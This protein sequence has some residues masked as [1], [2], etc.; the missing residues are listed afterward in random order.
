MGEVVQTMP[1]RVLGGELKRLRLAAGK[2]QEDIAEVVG[3]ARTR[4]NNLENGRAN[5]TADELRRVLDFLEVSPED[6]EKVLAMGVEARKRHPRRAKVDLLPSTYHRNADL[7][8]LA[9]R[10]SSYDR[11]VIPGLL[12]IPEYAE[13]LIAN[14]D[15]VWWEQSYQERVNRVAF[16][17][18]RQKLLSGKDLVFIFTDDA[19]AT[20]VGGAQ[21]MRQ[22]V[23]HLLEASERPNVSLRLLDST[24]P[25]NPCLYGPI[26]LLDFEEPAPPVGLLP[27]A[28]GPS[29]YLREPGDTAALARGLA[30]LQ[31]LAFSLEESRARLR[32]V[33]ERI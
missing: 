18:E 16:R 31:E 6:R 2:S 23:E 26:V 5:L 21:V 1:R 7:E 9:V 15:G 33:L 14:G 10:I 22:Q 20:L 8:S 32:A 12:Q 13:A 28:Y 29:V 19:L 27:V 17:L 11:G 30:R 25:K 3:K 24:E 4:I